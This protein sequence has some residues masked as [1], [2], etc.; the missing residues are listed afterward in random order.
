MQL[1]EQHII[2]KSDPRYEAIDRAAFAS[3]NLY[4]AANYFVRQAFIFQGTYTGYA[5]LFHMLKGHEAY[6]ALPR[7]VSNDVLRLLDKNWKSFFQAIKAWKAYPERFSGRPKLPGYKDKVAGRNILIYDI[8]ALSKKALKRGLIQPS[9]LGITIQTQQRSVKQV[10]I[11]PKS[12][13]YVVEVI[14]EQ[15][16]EPASGD[17]SL[18]AGIDLGL[19]NLA[20][21]TSNK[22]GF[23]PRLIS[24]K[25]LKSMNQG[26][27]KRRAELPPGHGKMS[28]TKSCRIVR[29]PGHFFRRNCQ[30]YIW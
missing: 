10:R 25:L 13:H 28:R 20:T 6:Q 21:L 12:T 17:A 22:P 26:Y 16:P 1:V 11:V 19:D 7:K 30:A 9:Q 27:N 3:K 29:P 4:N 5:E 8:Q 18:V 14:Y 15:E 23:V 24:G 2:E